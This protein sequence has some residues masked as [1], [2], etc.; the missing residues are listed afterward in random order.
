[1]LPARVA[2]PCDVP[3]IVRVTNAAYVVESF[4]ITGTRTDDD[5]VRRLIAQPQSAFFVVDDPAR[6]GRLR[7]SVYVETVGGAGYFAMLAVDPP[8]QGSGLAR[9]LMH[10]IEDHC[11]AAGCSR[12]DFD[13]TNLREEL[14]A[15]Y[16]KFGFV[17]VG[18]AEMGDRHK[19][20]QPCIASRCRSG[21][22]GERHGT[23]RLSLS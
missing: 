15:F 7:A 23:A 4:F 2:S 3:E 10:V 14:P 12:I 9:L 19:L 16:A 8:H 18:T 13:M 5:E 21:C 20:T 22:D 1:V 6:A 17:Q 11:R